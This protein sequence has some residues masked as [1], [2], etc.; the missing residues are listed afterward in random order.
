VCLRK[1]PTN[2]TEVAVPILDR[3]MLGI[4][5]LVVILALSL[6]LLALHANAIRVE[7]AHGS[8]T[9]Q[10]STTTVAGC[11]RE[12]RVHVLSYFSWKIIPHPHSIVKWGCGKQSI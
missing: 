8:S 2:A 9:F 7:H 1:S 5:N 12:K 10:A 11:L 4:A 3:L 6:F